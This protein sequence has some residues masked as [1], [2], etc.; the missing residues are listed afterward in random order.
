MSDQ[1]AEPKKKDD[2]PKGPK[3]SKLLP[4]LV[5]V[6]LA[7]TGF[8]AFKVMTTAPAH[9]EPPP[10]EHPKPI[11]NEVVGPVIA[12]DAF[13]VNLDEPGTSRYLKLTIQLELIS[14][15]AEAVITKNK[16]LI[17]DGV[18]SH[19]SGLKHADTLGAPAK[20]KLRTAIMEKI[21]KFVGP[22]QVRRMFFQEFVVQ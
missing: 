12:M 14:P 17:R 1:P 7:A 5:V 11:S 16:Q 19:L 8:T 21:E 18:L 3:G 6:N 2:K 10:P 13:V 9:A 15:E 4:L 22:N 20:E